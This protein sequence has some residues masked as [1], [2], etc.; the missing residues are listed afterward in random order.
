MYQPTRFQSLTLKNVVKEWIDKHGTNHAVSCLCHFD[1]PALLV[2]ALLMLLLA[3]GHGEGQDFEPPSAH[4]K[5]D[6]E[7]V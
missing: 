2:V 6:Q 7:K 1:N 4:G 5:P 3:V